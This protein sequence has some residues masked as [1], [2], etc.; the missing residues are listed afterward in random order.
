[1]D[2]E[3]NVHRRRQGFDASRPV[4]SFIK[5]VRGVLI[6]PARFYAGLRESRE[7][8]GVGAP[9]LFAGICLAI[10]LLLAYLT[11]PLD[12]LASEEAPNPLFEF[13]SSVQDDPGTV[14]LFAI[15]LLVLVPL[16]AILGVYIGAIVQHLFVL[17][18]VRERRGFWATFLVV[19]YSSAIQLL[20]WIPVLGYLISLYGIYVT[21]IGLRELHS[22]TTI[23]ALL[24]ALTPH[25]LLLAGSVSILS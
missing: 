18:F 8:G 23:R 10:G 11:A 16:G 24:A 1:M 14:I 15:L 13:F 4:G 12:P 25:L 22:T 20:S 2:A 3:G 19:A 6:E 17:M 9:L 5:V 21:T 7:E